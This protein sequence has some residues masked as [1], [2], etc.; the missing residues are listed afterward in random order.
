MGCKGGAAIAVEIRAERSSPRI[1]SGTNCRGSAGSQG[2][3]AKHLA[4]TACFWLVLF[5][6]FW[7][8]IAR[9]LASDWWAINYVVLRRWHV[10]DAHENIARRSDGQPQRVTADVASTSPRYELGKVA[11]SS[12]FLKRK[13]SQRFGASS[14]SKFHHIPKKSL[15][16]P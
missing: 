16:H 11:F 14:F 1:E 13:K 9:G 7:W 10:L 4:N 6:A 15:Y 2:G 8:T 12:M 5:A 3:V